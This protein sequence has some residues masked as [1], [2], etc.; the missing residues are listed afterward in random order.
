MSAITGGVTVRSNLFA[1][2][3][4][5]ELATGKA[6][7]WKDIADGAGLNPNTVYS[8]AR[9][10]SGGMRFETMQG[11]LA[12]FNKEG[13]DVQPGDLFVMERQPA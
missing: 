1:L 4:E 12:F 11:L 10:Q 6:Y 8:L 5:L 7:S 9:E 2:K 13:L 3:R